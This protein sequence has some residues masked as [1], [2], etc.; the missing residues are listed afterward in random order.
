MFIEQCRKNVLESM[1]DN[2]E[3]KNKN[4]WDKR[5]FLL[6]GNN[7]ISYQPP[8]WISNSSLHFL[9]FN[10]FFLDKVMLTP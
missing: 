1:E 6:T 9:H 5:N 4:L 7:K 10:F 2:M 3:D 8:L